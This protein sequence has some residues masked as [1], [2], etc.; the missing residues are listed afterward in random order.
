MVP[1]FVLFINGILIAHYISGSFSSAQNVMC[2]WA[3]SWAVSELLSPIHIFSM[4]DL[5]NCHGHHLPF[6]RINDTVRPDADRPCPCKI[7]L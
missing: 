4:T 7:T 5:Q 6:Y 1:N 3:N 2:Y